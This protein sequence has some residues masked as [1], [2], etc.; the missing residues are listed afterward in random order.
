MFVL[1]DDSVLTRPHE[2]F[3]G[4]LARSGLG[5]EGSVAFKHAV[6]EALTRRD[7]AGFTEKFTM[8]FLQR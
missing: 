4:E 8:R 2:M 1:Q 3:G 6:V 7:T 5:P